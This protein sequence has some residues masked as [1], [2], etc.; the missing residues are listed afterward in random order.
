MGSAIAAA[1]GLSTA[2]PRICPHN[3]TKVFL[4]QAAY[5]IMEGAPPRFIL[6]LR[7]DSILITE[8]PLPPLIALRTRPTVP[9]SPSFRLFPPR[10]P[11]D[12]QGGAH[13][14]RAQGERGA[15]VL[16]LRLAARV[17]ALCAL[18]PA[19]AAVF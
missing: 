5:D 18:A 6:F 10:E 1:Q 7:F 15:A 8:L 14:A 12:R 13:Q 2:P 19:G 4:P 17:Y 16:L 9:P 11:L 3:A